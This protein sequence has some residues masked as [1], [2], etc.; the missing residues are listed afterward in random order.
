M[1]NPVPTLLH[2]SA[3]SGGSSGFVSGIEIEAPVGSSG[4]LIT[5]YSTDA[6]GSALFLREIG[7]EFLD[8]SISVCDPVIAPPGH[9]PVLTF[10]QGRNSSGDDALVGYPPNGAGSLNETAIIFEAG[11]KENELFDRPV[12]VPPGWVAVFSR[13]VNPGTFRGAFCIRELNG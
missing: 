6:T 12:F 13:N 10:R 3:L 9:T 1:P 4:L 7:D 8:N 2:Y 5:H 11:P